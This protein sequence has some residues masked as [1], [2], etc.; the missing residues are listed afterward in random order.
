MADKDT[1]YSRILD[2][3][4]AMCR[5]YGRSR[6]ER[7]RNNYAY[8]AGENLPPDNVGQPL[9]I[10]YAKPI[11][12]KH[13]HY[14]WG[15]WQEGRDIVGWQVDPLGNTEEDRKLAQSIVDYCYGVARK[16]KA[17]VLFFDTGLNASIFGDAVLRVTWDNILEQVRWESILPEFVHFRWSPSN[18]DEIK[19]VVI[20]YPI[21]SADALEEFGT[22]GHSRWRMDQKTPLDIMQF[23]L[24][25]ELWTPK[26][27]DRYIDDVLVKSVPN[28]VLGVNLRNFVHIA[29]TRA[30]GEFYGFADCESVYALQDEINGKLADEGDTITNFAHPIT[31]MRKYFGDVE[32]LP[33]GPDSV[34]DLGREGEAEYLQWKGTPPAIREYVESIMQVIFDTASMS[35]VAFGRHKGTQQSAIALAV[36]ML[37]VTERARWKRAL[38]T[39]GLRDLVEVSILVEAQNKKLPFTYEQF[40]AHRVNVLWAPMLP[41]DEAALVNEN[42]ALFAAHVRSLQNVLVAMGEPDPGSEEARIW[43]DLKKMVE[44]GMKIAPPTASGSSSLPEGA[45]QNTAKGRPQVKGD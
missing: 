13:N 37:P 7:Y 44:L 12:E 34:W 2:F 8:F 6:M 5:R 21:S 18:L 30:G 3:E 4:N 11:S 26:T 29:N 16:N 20:S 38:W 33:V 1:A 25:W 35:P 23:P 36:E 19:E 42:V 41:R 27:F 24:Y 14:L 40:K 31:I 17:D 39:S 32:D 9:G 43:A 28:P 10:N 22:E 45:N 15:Q